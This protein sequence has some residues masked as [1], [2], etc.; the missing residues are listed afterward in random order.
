ML[1]MKRRRRGGAAQQAE[2][3]D[4]WLDTAELKQ[5][6]A[7]VGLGAGGPGRGGLLH[8]LPPGSGSWG[9]PRSPSRGSVWLPGGGRC[10]GTAGW[11]GLAEQG[12][13][14]DV[15]QKRFKRCERDV[16]GLAKLGQCSR[17]GT[18]CSLGPEYP[19]LGDP[20]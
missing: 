20:A 16:M 2:A 6:E 11:E 18:A 1:G 17:A 8:P 9:V 7:Q 19:A 5:S 10:C 4:V 12:C 13:K 14:S 15:T 3:C